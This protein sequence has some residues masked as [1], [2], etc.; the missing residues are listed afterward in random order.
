MVD[1]DPVGSVLGKD[2]SNLIQSHTCRLP[3]LKNV[4]VKREQ[5]QLQRQMNLVDLIC[6]TDHAKIPIPIRRHKHQGHVFKL[7]ESELIVMSMTEYKVMEP[8]KIQ[9]PHQ[10]AEE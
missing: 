7:L 3:G 9:A 1:A 10:H 4:Q 6:K 2:R 8:R 5:V